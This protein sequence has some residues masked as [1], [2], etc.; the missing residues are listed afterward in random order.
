MGGSASASAPWCSAT[1]PGGWSPDCSACGVGDELNFGG[2]STAAATEF[3]PSPY[4]NEPKSTAS[5]P[6]TPPPLAHHLGA[7]LA[8]DGPDAEEV[9]PPIRAASSTGPIRPMAPVPLSSTADWAAQAQHSHLGPPN[10][11]RQPPPSAVTYADAHRKHRLPNLPGATALHELR[12]TAC[13]EGVPVMPQS[14]TLP[15]GPKPSAS[16]QFAALQTTAHEAHAATSL[17]ALAMDACPEPPEE[18]GEEQ[19]WVAECPAAPHEAPDSGVNGDTKQAARLLLRRCYLTAASWSA[20]AL[21]LPGAAD[22]A[23]DVR[24]LARC[25]ILFVYRSAGGRT[26]DLQLKHCPAAGA[27]K[28]VVAWTR[29]GGEGDELE[30]TV[31]FEREHALSRTSGAASSKYLSSEGS[32]SFRVY[33]RDPAVAV[34]LRWCYARACQDSEASQGCTRWSRLL[35]DEKVF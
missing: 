22:M 30:F 31:R 34:L 23:E 14:L 1:S 11:L 8:A 27:D 13:A 17:P 20:R 26:K 25:I 4:P 5:S 19:Q 33:E 32:I 24:E 29:E 18:M 7:P 9:Q 15:R 3:S 21:P 6:S 12:D 2:A 28:V 35:P 10:I 16:V